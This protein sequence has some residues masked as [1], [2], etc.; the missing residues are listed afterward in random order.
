MSLVI[1]PHNPHVPTSHANV[2]FFIAEKEGE[3]A[4][5][6]FGGGFDLTPYYGNEEDC[7]HWHRVAEQ[8]CAPFGADVYPRYKAGATATSTS[9]TVAS[10]AALVACSSMT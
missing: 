5:W 1:H 9:S 10:H 2:R 3:E 4:V 6:W 7:I 8:A